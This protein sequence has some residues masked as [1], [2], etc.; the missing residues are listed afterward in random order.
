NMRMDILIPTVLGAGIGILAFSWILSWVFKK[1]RNQTIA[2]LSGFIM[3]SLGIL[4]P[5]K[6][7]ISETF[8]GEIKAVGYEWYLPQINA[9]FAVAVVIIIAGFV[10]IW[11]MEYAASEKEAA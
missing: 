4:W 8:N 7:V 9:E 3:G 1:Y 5:W 11:A 6:N 2:L 10:S